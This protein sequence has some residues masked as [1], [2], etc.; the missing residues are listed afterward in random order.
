M[1]RFR[2]AT[3]FVLSLL[4]VQLALVGSGYACAAHVRHGADRHTA[5]AMASAAGYGARA[6]PAMGGLA[7]GEDHSCGDSESG[8]PCALP[9]SGASCTGPGACA[10]TLL[11]GTAIAASDL[12]PG[13]AAL[14]ADPALSPPTRT[15][16]PE[17]PPP[18][19]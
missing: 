17:L 12:P 2:R 15:L 19:A 4:L 8:M 5:S 18:R 3:A 6:M 13:H 16:V 10:T 11:G 14:S 7:V 9:G 1:R